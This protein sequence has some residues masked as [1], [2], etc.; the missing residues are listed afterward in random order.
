MSDSRPPYEKSVDCA[1][2]MEFEIEDFSR[3]KKC[4]KTTLQKEFEP[5][6]TE[7]LRIEHSD[8]SKIKTFSAFLD[9][10]ESNARIKFDK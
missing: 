10:Q 4:A 3:D 6:V 2:P 9:Y 8:K 5:T 1:K 7:K